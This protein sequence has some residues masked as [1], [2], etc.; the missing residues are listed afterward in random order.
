MPAAVADEDG[1]DSVGQINTFVA[2]PDSERLLDVTN[3]LLVP[4]GELPDAGGALPSPE[5]TPHEAN[6]A[7]SISRSECHEHRA[8]SG[9]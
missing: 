3:A 2:V 1:A 8:D 4:D 6:A 9:T 5:A 7:C